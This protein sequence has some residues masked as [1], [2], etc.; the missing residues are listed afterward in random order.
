MDIDDIKKNAR[1][2]SHK[3][4]VSDLAYVDMAGIY[5]KLDYKKYRPYRKP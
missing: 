2:V 3:S 5:P 1:Q 4:T